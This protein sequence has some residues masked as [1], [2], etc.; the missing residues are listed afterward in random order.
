VLFSLNADGMAELFEQRSDGG[1]VRPEIFI[2]PDF[3]YT[4]T[5]FG[6]W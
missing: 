3:S 6:L 5:A 2:D 1:Y 4:H